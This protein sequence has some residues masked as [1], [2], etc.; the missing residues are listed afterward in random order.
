MNK[1]RS[2]RPRDEARVEFGDWQT[3]KPLAGEVLALLAR[4]GYAPASVV[5]PTCGEGSFLSAAARQFPGAKLVG[6]EISEAY[7]AKAR[8]NLA[9]VRNAEVNVADFFDVRWEKVLSVLPDPLLIVGNPPW[10][11]NSALGVLESGNLPKKANFKKHS[12]FDAMTGRSNF[13]IS[14]WMLIRLLESLHTRPFTMAMLCKASVARRLMEHADANGWPINGELR[15]IDA[16]LHFAAAVDAVL[17]WIRGSGKSLIRGGARWPVFESLDALS[18]VTVMGVVDGRICSNVDAYAKTRSLEGKSEIEWRSG[19]KHDCA[20]VMELA[21][22][23]GSLTNGF[24]EPVDVEPEYVFPLLKGS[25]IANGRLTPTRAVIV[26]Q[27]SL[28]ENTA[29]LKEQAPKLWRYL[30]EHRQHL[31]ARKSSIYREQPPFAVF[32]VGDYSFAP[33]KVAICGLYK[34]L[35]F[36]VVKPI[37][38]RPV[39]F[40]DTVYFLPCSTLDEAETLAA[41]LA[42][43]HAREFFNARVFWDAKRP[44]GKAILQSISLKALLRVEGLTV[45]RLSRATQVQVAL[46]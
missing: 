30:D 8:D 9:D 17:L 13:D 45:E 18:P 39:I 19:L 1:P 21:A 10:V 6:F 43:E 41:A 33:F 35:A 28:G 14:E 5:E 42:S 44:I 38:K 24:G 40:D 7:A 25:D 20:K 32:G 46:F 15:T 26:P 36:T 3:P 22:Q 29:V 27:R 12:G 2:H 23:S 16:R 31:D 37:E 34:R 4:D 11:T